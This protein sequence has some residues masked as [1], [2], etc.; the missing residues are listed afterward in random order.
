MEES[1]ADLRQPQEYSVD[2]SLPTDTME[3]IHKELAALRQEV[4]ELR[5]LFELFLGEQRP[6]E[7]RWHLYTRQDALERSI[8]L[9]KRHLKQL[10]DSGKVDGESLV[11]VAYVEPDLAHQPMWAAIRLEASQVPQRMFFSESKRFFQQMDVK[12]VRTT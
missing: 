9:L 2:A 6:K 12:V 8:L 1:K 4:A 11:K 10:V 5:R 7:W 3:D